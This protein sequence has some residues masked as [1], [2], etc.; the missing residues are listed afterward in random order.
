MPAIQI[1]NK[2]TW[3]NETGLSVVDN[4]IAYLT[5]SSTGGEMGIFREMGSLYRFRRWTSYSSVVAK[6]GPD[7][8][9]RNG[10]AYQTIC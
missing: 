3:E 8:S 5:Q 1:L 10:Q 2:T 4:T 6:F 7:V 9:S